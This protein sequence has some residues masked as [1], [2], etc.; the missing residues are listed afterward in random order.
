MDRAPDRDN[1]Q[2]CLPFVPVGKPME[3]FIP[4]E[5]FQKKV[6]PPEVLPFFFAFIETTG[7]FRTIYLH[8]WCRLPL[9]VKVEGFK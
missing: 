4:T 2:K 8:Y 6:I 1:G 3:R 7:I 9:E 5:F